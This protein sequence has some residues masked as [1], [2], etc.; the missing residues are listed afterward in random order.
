MLQKITT[1]LILITLM[2]FCKGLSLSMLSHNVA[3]QD[4]THS[5]DQNCCGDQ[6]ASTQDNSF[7]EI[8]LSV[9]SQINNNI[10]IFAIIL[11]F[12]G[13][14]IINFYTK[15]LLYIKNLYLTRGSPKLF[16]KFN[17]FIYN[18]LL[19]KKIYC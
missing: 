8:S 14:I 6:S 17:R 4:M 1:I 18:G 9:I 2:F 3:M 13:I 11:F 12:V 16:F 5:E 19:N 15:F 7:H 10:N